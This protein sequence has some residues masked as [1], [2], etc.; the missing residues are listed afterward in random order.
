MCKEQLLQYSNMIQ[1]K[2]VERYL[3]EIQNFK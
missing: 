3:I 1:D 2:E